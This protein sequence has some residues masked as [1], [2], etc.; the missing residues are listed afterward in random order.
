MEKSYETYAKKIL[1]FMNTHTQEAK[2]IFDTANKIATN[3]RFSDFG[4]KEALD[5][6]K[7][8]LAELNKQFSDSIRGAVKQFCKEYGVSYAEDNADHTADIANALKIMEM[9]G[10]NLTGDLFRTAIEPMKGSY[11]ALKIVQEILV[12]KANT[13]NAYSDEIKKIIYEYIGVNSEIAA[14]MDR[15]KEIEEVA[16]YPVLVNYEL[17]NTGYN[18]AYRFELR[19]TTTYSVYATPD[20]MMEVG[21]MYEELAMKYPL[22]FSNYVPEDTIEAK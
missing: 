15:L 13:G 14:Y 8:Q 4:K 20:W 12:S 3:Q 11:R 9:V 19:E 18:G 16:D 22:I 5:A 2:K 17:A 10:T 6:L 1:I 7:V 21:K